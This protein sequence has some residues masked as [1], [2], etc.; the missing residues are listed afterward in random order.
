MPSPSSTSALAYQ[1]DAAA[2]LRMVHVGIR[3]PQAPFIQQRRQQPDFVAFLV[4][5]GEI[6]LTDEMPDGI[7]RVTVRPG[8]V[9]VVAPGL[10]QAS[11][12]PFPAGIV[13]LWF[14]F[15]IGAFRVLDTAAT[16]DQ[17]RE[18]HQPAQAPSAGRSPQR[19]WLIPRHL[20]FG[21]AL[22]DVMRAHTA[23]IENE[24]LWGMDDRGSQAIGA[25]LVYR[26][27]RA[28][29]QSRLR[30]RDIMRTAP[31]IAHV[32]RARE[33]IR[34]NHERPISL[35]S[36]ANAIDLNP[37]YLSRCFGKVARHTVGEAILAARIET[38]KRLLIEGHA[39]KEA[40]YLSGFA[41][42]SYFCRRFRRACGT[43]PLDYAA[44][45]ASAAA[46]TPA[47]IQRRPGE[48]RPLR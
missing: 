11:T 20:Q 15:T 21:D 25:E 14:H 30:G 28:F 41:S 32:A 38:A 26:L 44:P 1:V 35:A 43:T 33:F 5:K 16:D 36:V 22:E 24:R 13:F 2:S 34:L 6:E 40:A 31:E 48:R 7:E 18:L 29:V 12:R 46:R 27:H 8:E 37:A 19:H 9:H 3:A 42:A 10:W 4:I 23:L 47:P 17:V 39:V 45:V